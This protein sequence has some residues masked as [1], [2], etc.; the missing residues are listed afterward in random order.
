[1]YSLYNPCI[2]KKHNGLW[3]Q[4]THEIHELWSYMYMNNDDSTVIKSCF[5][6]SVYMYIDALFSQEDSIF[7]SE[8]YSKMKW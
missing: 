6:T 1:M 3:T 2:N 7:Y 5:S 8:L 4:I